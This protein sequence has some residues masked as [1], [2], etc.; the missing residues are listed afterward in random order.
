V[1][2]P[3]R[4]NWIAAGKPTRTA[5][6]SSA[7]GV[8]DTFPLPVNPS[9][10]RLLYNIGDRALTYEEMLALTTDPEALSQLIAD[11]V[12]RCKCGQSFNQEQFVVLGDLLRMPGVP[13][14]LRAGLFEVAKRLPD[15]AVVGDAKDAAGRVGVAIARYEPYDQRN[16]LIFDPSSGELLGERTVATKAQT[17]DQGSGGVPV[18]AG[19]VLYET[20]YLKSGLVDNLTDEPS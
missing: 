20:A 6:P 13:S 12:R 10:A 16:E 9:Q 5:G 2:E 3:Y 4:D 15:I 8:D 7:Q 11:G 17:L 1:P 19:T 18:A 14:S